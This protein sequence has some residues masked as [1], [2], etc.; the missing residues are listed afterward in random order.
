MIDVPFFSVLVHR[1]SVFR[2]LVRLKAEALVLQHP[3]K[4]AAA[5]RDPVCN[6]RIGRPSN[7][8]TL[9]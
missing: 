7:R 8:K 3:I 2:S 4:M 9:A 1:F 6:C 5:S